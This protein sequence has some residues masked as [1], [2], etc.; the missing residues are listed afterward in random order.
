MELIEV[1]EQV[2]ANR[3]RKRLALKKGLDEAAREKSERKAKAKQER[4][5][6]QA[7]GLRKRIARMKVQL[8]VEEETIR[9]LEKEAD[10]L[11]AK[12]AE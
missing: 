4:R 7:K 10:A 8:R 5:L 2:E 3:E 11:E 1:N 12:S 6:Q 9:L